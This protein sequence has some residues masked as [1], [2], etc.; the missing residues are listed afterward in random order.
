[1]RLFRNV[2]KMTLKEAGFIDFKLKEILA[3]NKAFV[4]EYKEEI[5][6]I[7]LR[8]SL[9]MVWSFVPKMVR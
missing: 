4:S 6:L 5:P 9:F 2:N 8:E 7:F 3:A 1:M